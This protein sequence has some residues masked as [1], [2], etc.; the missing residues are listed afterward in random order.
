[1]N[2]INAKVKILI[3]GPLSVKDYKIDGYTIKKEKYNEKVYDTKNEDFIFYA[4]NYL[5]SSIYQ[6]E[7]DEQIY[8]DCL[9]N[10]D[11]IELNV[12]DDIYNNHQE[13]NNFVIDYMI[14]KVTFLEMKLRLITNFSIG[15]PAFR[16]SLF[17][18][19]F[20][21]ITFGA[22]IKDEPPVLGARGYSEEQRKFICDRLRLYIADAT[23]IDIRDKNSRYKRAMEFYNSSFSTGEIGVRFTLLFT[24]LESLFNLTGRSVTENIAKYTSKMMFET[25]VEERKIYDKM[26][27]FYDIRSRYIHGNTPRTIT[28]EDEFYLREIVREVLLMYWYTFQYKQINTAEDVVKFLEISNIHTIDI[29][30]QIF[31]KSLHMLKYEDFYNEIKTK[32]SNGITDLF[33]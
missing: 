20:Q 3:N 6:V 30:L 25:Q 16:V 5:I 14:E 26:K 33:Q 10:D 4:S 23:L 28:K 31:K 9:E 18:E 27:D 13:L 21:F 22:D 2:K 1:M 8:Y 11:Y 12:K 17:N 32:I 7:N 19:D 29:Q 15:L 24:S